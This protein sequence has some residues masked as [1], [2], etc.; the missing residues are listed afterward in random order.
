MVSLLT[1][2]RHVVDW[3][4][5]KFNHVFS[6]NPVGIGW[7]RDDKL[8]SG[9]VFHDRKYHETEG[10]IYTTGPFAREFLRAYHEY[11][12]IVLGVNRINASCAESNRK[13]YLFLNRMGYK[14]EG[15]RR[16]GYPNGETKYL[17]GMLKEECK[18]LNS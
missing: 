11:A 7:V 2:G 10:S 9:V 3:V 17:F 18:W 14:L 5:G 12:F 4:Q 16:K 13:S 6:G 8:V 15:A 1:Q